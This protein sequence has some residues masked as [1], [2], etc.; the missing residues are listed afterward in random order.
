MKRARVREPSFARGRAGAREVP[1]AGVISAY[2][3]ELEGEGLGGGAVVPDDRERRG[4]DGRGGAV[5]GG[6]EVPREDVEE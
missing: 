2:L 1:R 5:E 3:A 4:V 6:G